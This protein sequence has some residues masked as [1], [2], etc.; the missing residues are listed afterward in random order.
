MSNDIRKKVTN[1]NNIANDINRLNITL[2]TQIK[3]NIKPVTY[4]LKIDILHLYFG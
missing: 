1:L 4:I 2:V 3:L